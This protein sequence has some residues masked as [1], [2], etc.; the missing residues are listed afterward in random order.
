MGNLSS[1]IMRLESVM[2]KVVLHTRFDIC[3]ASL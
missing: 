2:K 1:G 3:S